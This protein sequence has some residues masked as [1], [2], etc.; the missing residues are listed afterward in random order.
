[1]RACVS[2]LV[3]M[4]SGSLMPCT[5]APEA[6]CRTHTDMNT[7]LSQDCPADQAQVQAAASALLCNV[8]GTVRTCSHIN[9]PCHAKATPAGVQHSF[10]GGDAKWCNTIQ[11]P[12]SVGICQ[13]EVLRP[14]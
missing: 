11:L 13:A 1:M 4:A 9:L 6:S 2:S 7:A 5:E 3:M 8:E 10:P 14:K 12:S